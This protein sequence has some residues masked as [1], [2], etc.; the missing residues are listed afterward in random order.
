[1]L[2]LVR[3]ML[4]KWN[5]QILPGMD[6]GRSQCLDLKIKLPST[7][8]TPSKVLVE[9][10][11]DSDSSSD[12]EDSNSGDNAARTENRMDIDGEET[13]EKPLLFEGYDNKTDLK[14]GVEN[15]C[16]QAVK[17]GCRYGICG[18]CF[19]N[20]IDSSCQCE[21]LC[22]CDKCDDDRNIVEMLGL[23][24]GNQGCRYRKCGTCCRLVC[25][26]SCECE[27]LCDCHECVNMIIDW[28][29]AEEREAGA[30]S[31]ECNKTSY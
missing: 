31:W 8:L 9:V 3:R 15:V 28:L 19:I 25:D 16:A 2:Q 23:L 26:G 27:W 17:Q 11:L 4:S 10:D 12:C 21:W 1:M 14:G 29:L 7:Q 13:M 5:V 22:P 6:Q 18:K 24:P 30:D 20:G